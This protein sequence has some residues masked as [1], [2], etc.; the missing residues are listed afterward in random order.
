MLRVVV[1]VTVP[2]QPLFRVPRPYFFPLV[3][4]VPER[5]PRGARPPLPNDVCGVGMGIGRLPSTYCD[6][7]IGVWND[8]QFPFD[9][10]YF[11]FSTQLQTQ[12]T[13]RLS[14]EGHP[15]VGSSHPPWYTSR[16][17]L[18]ER[19]RGIK[20]AQRLHRDKR[21]NPHPRPR[22]G[23]AGTECFPRRPRRPRGSDF[24]TGLQPLIYPPPPP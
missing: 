21:E 9:E 10:N 16:T 4:A 8:F 20:H 7:L 24:S 23:S 19:C 6:F 2:G 15:D 1:A 17:P 12:K 22:S 3:L 13:Y 18:S 11:Y 14:R 5:I